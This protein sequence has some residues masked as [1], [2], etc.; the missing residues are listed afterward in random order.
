[1]NTLIGC[2]SATIGFA[3]LAG[4]VT[5]SDT[6]ASGRI[7]EVNAESKTF[8]LTD[9]TGKDNSFKLSQK[10]VVNRAGKESASD[11]RVDDVIDVCYEKGILT[12]TA[13]YILI[14]EGESKTSKLVRGSV[15]GY[16][17]A[18]KELTFS[19][20]GRED[21]TYPMGKATVQFDGKDGTVENV[22]IGDRA[23]IIVDMVESVATLRTLRLDRAN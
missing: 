14:Q 18:K 15:K 17:A 2:M 20:E 11:L 16:D 19:S 10:I 1:M 4:T 6:V 7:K 5:A 13:H 3:L 22:K 23:M 8:V 12:W 9:S 21:T